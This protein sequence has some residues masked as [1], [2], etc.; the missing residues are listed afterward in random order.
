MDIEQLR[1]KIRAANKA[2]WENPSSDNDVS[3]TE[4]DRLVENLRLLSP[5]DPLLDEIGKEQ[6]S[7]YKVAHVK[8]MLSL[9]K[10][11]DWKSLVLWATSV[12]RNDDEV[13]MVSPKYDGLSLEAQGDRIVTRGDGQIGTDI[14]HLS[15]HIYVISRFVLDDNPDRPYLSDK[16]PLDEV[17]DHSEP[18]ERYVGELLIPYWRFDRLK[19]LYP[20][21]FGSYKTPRNLCAGFANS[22][23]SADMINVNGE[24]SKMCIA[25]FVCHRAFEIPITLKELK[26]GKD[27]KPAIM[28]FV[29]NKHVDYP[30]DGIVFRL[31]DDKYAESLG[32]TQHHPLGSKAFKFTSEQVTVTITNIAWQVGEQHVSPIAEFEPVR[33]DSVMV[34]R[35]TL[36]NPSWM[37]AN[38]VVVGSKAVIERRGGVIPRVMKVINDDPNVNVELP[39]VCPACGTPL[40]KDGLFLK[41]PSD[42]CTGKI[43]TKIV[44]G[45]SVFGIKGA[46]PALVTKAIQTFYLR[47]IIDWATNFGSRDP[48]T[49]DLLKK[50]GFTNN[51]IKV[52]TSIATVMND[53]STLVNILASVCIPK[54]STDFVNTVER[55]CGGISRLM[56]ICPVDR[57]YDE[58]VDKCKSDSV[59]NFMLWMEENYERFITYVN[60]FRI[61]EYTKQ[62]STDKIVCFTGTGPK[63]RKELLA[64]AMNNGYQVTE[65]ANQCT[66][67]VAA[68]PNGSSS[69]LQKAR[70]K[71]IKVIG[72]EEFLN[73][74][75]V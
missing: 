22:K 70:A 51:E 27:P 53:G 13:F 17:L 52:L 73:L 58:I 25:D 30:V 68:D 3:D 54:C 55:D 61:L 57:M 64:L 44:R 34:K 23:D 28:K 5:N 1:E 19:S 69:K 18:D 50:K 45:L 31:A 7:D 39:T 72:Y 36:H 46:G 11:Y 2:Y 12:A 15:S 35:A 71:G 63:P 59:R 47:D 21:V 49:I 67:L 75:G 29:N 60:M 66:V 65:N 4:Y 42:E 24:G 33:L 48:S 26:E 62:A 8:P 6:L 37:Q 43:A 40:V 10:V 38:K 56:S 14:S 16:M 32:S 41:C 9:S 20:D 74:V